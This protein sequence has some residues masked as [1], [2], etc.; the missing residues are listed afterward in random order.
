M[1]AAHISCSKTS[2]RGP[3]FACIVYTPSSQSRTRASGRRRSFARTHASGAK[4]PTWQTASSQ[5]ASSARR[6]KRDGGRSAAA[7]GGATGATVSSSASETSATAAIALRSNRE[8]VRDRA[9]VGGCSASASERK[10]ASIF[11]AERGSA[12]DE[13]RR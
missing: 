2:V 3:C 8:L 10:Q 9:S 13:A 12:V 7:A 1:N 6:P 11:A 4:P 5:R